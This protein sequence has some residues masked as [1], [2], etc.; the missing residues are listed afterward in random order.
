MA[1]RT[2]CGLRLVQTKAIMNTR[3]SLHPNRRS[4]AFNG[5][6]L[7]ELLVV[8]AIIAILG[9]FLLPALVRAREQARL[10][11]C[12]SNL[13]QIGIG[14]EMYR[15]DNRERFPLTKRADNWQTF[16]YGGGDPDR[17]WPENQLALPATNR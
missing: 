15:S 7:I 1:G 12:R 5:F 4:D 13:R 9:S 2:D 17:K 16:Q 10:T 14:F 8:I 11:Q 6:T 3:R